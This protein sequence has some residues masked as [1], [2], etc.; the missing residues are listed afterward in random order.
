MGEFR[1]RLDQEARRVSGQAGALD[2]VM[3]RAGRRR[4]RRQVV[5]G[6]LALAIAGGSFAL[7]VAAF[8]GPGTAQPAVGPSPSDPVEVRVVAGGDPGIAAAVASSLREAGY[9]ILADV[10]HAG[11][12]DRTTTIACPPWFDDEALAIANHLGVEAKIV[13]ALPKS[14]YDL[15]VY[16]GSDYTRAA[17]EELEGFIEGFVAAR[18]GLAAEEY[19]GVARRD[20]F[21]TSNRAKPRR[22]ELFLYGDG[23]VLRYRVDDVD[24]L[25]ESRWRAD[26]RIT[27]GRLDRCVRHAVERLTI[28]EPSDGTFRL[29]DARLV[30]ERYS[31]LLDR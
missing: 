11:R 21:E 16:I 28:W 14:D 10:A 8:R 12:P 25:M 24:R 2:G 20:Y 22:N 1:D 26:V 19:V 18:D 5:T 7:A 9:D 4:V 17:I 30:D 27:W 6:V 13:G 15:T 31:C 3:R 23:G 29:L